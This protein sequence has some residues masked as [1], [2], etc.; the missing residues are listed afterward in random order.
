MCVN[1]ICL[2]GQN[3]ATRHS[4]FPSIKYMKHWLMLV[5]LGALVSSCGVN[6]YVNNV[7]NVPL[8]NMEDEF[9]A[10]G[11]LGLDHIELQA[12]Y[13]V[14]Q[15]MAIMH[16]LYFGFGTKG[17]NLVEQYLGKRA[18]GDLGIGYYGGLKE[19]DIFEVYGGYGFGY[20]DFDYSYG[21]EDIEYKVSSK[22]HK[23]FLQTNLGICKERFKAALSLRANYVNFPNYYVEFTDWDACGFISCITTDTLTLNNLSTFILDPVITVKFG[24]KSVRFILQ[25]GFSFPVVRNYPRFGTRLFVENYPYPPLYT[26]FIFNTGLQFNLNFN[27][28]DEEQKESSIFGMHVH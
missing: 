6:T 23:V 25:A 4:L 24:G 18:Y 20:L 11:Y 27:K 22:Y 10:S 17:L 3:G 21:W 16:N 5:L 7:V 14:T 13:P 2:E 26:R 8:M 1:N 12:A 19:N 9:K 15:R 28:K